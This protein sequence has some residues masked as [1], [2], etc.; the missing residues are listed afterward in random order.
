MFLAYVDASERPDYKEREN[1]V[2]SAIITNEPSWRSIDN[3]M[4]IIKANHFPNLGDEEIEIHAKD[5]LNKDGIFAQL[6][7]ED[8]YAIFDNVF[9]FINEDSTQIAIIAV[10][11]D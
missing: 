1:Y 5:M 4:K 10:V 2:L 7:W 6:N 3:G 8:I 11:I 9:N